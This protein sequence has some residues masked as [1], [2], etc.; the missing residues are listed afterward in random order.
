MDTVVFTQGLLVLEVV[1]HVLNATIWKVRTGEK[2]RHEE[3]FRPRREGEGSIPGNKV[4]VEKKLKS[5][6]F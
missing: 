6:Y 5:I 1:G 3:E 2:L 4:Q